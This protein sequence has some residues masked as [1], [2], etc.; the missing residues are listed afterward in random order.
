MNVKNLNNYI[1]FIICL[2]C[3]YFIFHFQQFFYL[4]KHDY[5]LPF[6]ELIQIGRIPAS[7]CYHFLVNYLPMSLQ[8]NMQDFCSGIGAFLKALIF[9]SICFV[10][11]R[12]FFVLS[13]KKSTFSELENIIIIP[14]SFLLLAIPI[15][16]IKNYYIWYGTLIEQSI[17]FD[18]FI[19]FLFYFIFFIL[20]NNIII[21]NRE[22]DLFHK[23]LIVISSFL[24]GF[25]NEIFNI[26]VL[27]SIIIFAF[28]Y[29]IYTKKSPINKK[30]FLLIIPFFIGCI[31]FYIFSDYITG[32]SVASHPYNLNEILYNL[33]NYLYDFSVKY[34]KTL[35]VDNL[36][37]WFLII[38]FS[39]IIYRKNNMKAKLSQII[40]SS[41]LTG[42]LIT[43]LSFILFVNLANRY[44]CDYLFQRSE[45]RAI[46]CIILMFV[47]MTQLGTIYTLYNKSRKIINIFIIFVLLTLSFIYIK[48]NREIQKIYLDDKQLVYK[49]EKMLLV[50]NILGESV[51]FPESFL[52]N[53]NLHYCNIFPLQDNYNYEKR[54]DYQDFMKNKYFDSQYSLFTPYYEKQYG[55][56][57]IGFQYKN[58]ELANKEFAK[59]LE[60]L[61]LKDENKSNKISFK[62][63]NK[64]KNFDLSFGYIEKIK[65]NEENKNLLLKAKAYLYYK[66]NNYEEALDYYKKYLLKNENDIDALINCADI[67]LQKNDIENAEKLYYKL[68]SLD[69]NN[70]NFLYNI[71]KINYHNKH[72]IKVAIEI[73]DEMI[74]T[75]PNMYINY[76]NKG[77]ILLKNNQYKEAEA[78]F[79][80][81]KQKNINLIQYFLEYNNVKSI[82]DI[83]TKEN[84]ELHPP[85]Y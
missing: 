57:F 61:G 6:F 5:F 33:N 41:L 68:H 48:E 50:Y 63:L 11:S 79:D 67:Y 28:L 19:A 56:K 62:D 51:I 54:D 81:V 52:E 46:S 85:T 25:W 72:N 36:I 53:S 17:F 8:I 26:S 76:I 30:N 3:I 39:I 16:D 47:I 84:I 18:Y 14:V 55:K 29:C 83:Y 22:Y 60:M 27:F 4:N 1:N 23:I 24:L 35:F 9:F 70:M 77:A 2:F 65:V 59:R 37:L 43:N 40:C 45:Y 74:K 21:H 80:I 71:L 58:D 78:L 66:S 64:I 20:L 34:I 73:C 12:S 7:F 75:Q 13:E 38:L 49:I 31:S 42:Y 10:F 69:T 82:E 44:G 15:F 32:H